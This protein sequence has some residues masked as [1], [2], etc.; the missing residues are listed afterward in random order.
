M[1]LLPAMFRRDNDFV[2][3]GPPIRKKKQEEV[4]N[5]FL[6]FEKKI[7]DVE[8]VCDL[9]G[10]SVLVS[11]EIQKPVGVWIKHDGSETPSIPE[12]TKL[13]YRYNGYGDTVWPAIGHYVARAYHRGWSSITEYMIVE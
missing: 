12:G 8:S 13:K 10:T 1:S 6:E 3:L 4:K 2:S 5:E 9:V 7:F 11:V